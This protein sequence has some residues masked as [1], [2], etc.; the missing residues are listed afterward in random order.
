MPDERLQIQ[1]DLTRDEHAAA[2]RYVT[3]QLV[4]RSSRGWFPVL[5]CVVGAVCGG[6]IAYAYLELAG[7]YE[8]PS[9][10]WAAWGAVA[11]LVAWLVTV[12]HQQYR[13]RKIH[14]VSVA[15][16]GAIL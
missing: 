6:V 2:M 14:S 4:S 3:R 9:P 8:G 11:F 12:W 1:Y 5:L 16:D 13:V 7:G 15:D 10:Q